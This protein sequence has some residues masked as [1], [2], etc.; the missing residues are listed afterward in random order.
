MEGLAPILACITDNKFAVNTGLSLDTLETETKRT[1]EVVVAQ[2][3]ASVVATE[4]A[5]AAIV[6]A[7]ATV[8]ASVDA[9]CASVVAAVGV[10][11]V[12]VAASVAAQT[13]AL[14]EPDSVP[15]NK[16]L[17][18]LDIG[19]N[20]TNDSVEALYGLLEN[21][22]TTSVDVGGVLRIAGAPPG[23]PSSHYWP[24]HTDANIHMDPT[25][26]LDVNVNNWPSLLDVSVDNWPSVQSSSITNWPTNQH[27]TVT[28]WPA[29]QQAVITNFP[30]S[31]RIHMADREY[32]PVVNFTAGR[33]NTGSTD[34][35]WNNCNPA[36]HGITSGT[37]YLVDSGQVFDTD[38]MV[39]PL[40]SDPIR[41]PSGRHYTGSTDDV[42]VQP[43]MLFQPYNNTTL[44][45]TTVSPGYSFKA[46]NH[47]V[48]WP[49]PSESWTC[50]T[51]HAK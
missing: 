9:G 32:L 31:Q 22:I 27:T 40:G 26:S 34:N 29:T 5:S 18:S 14:T 42:V 24:V 2:G 46:P 50:L 12:S 36:W 48:F 45:E 1:N 13:L 15:T 19:I 6:A 41:V 8:E 44:A 33:H 25:H 49:H 11:A 4:A 21:C 38:A 35:Y 30:V 47:E 16:N 20:K 28:N 3:E 17:H 10:N 7:V 43:S 37:T 39:F 23:G 51:T